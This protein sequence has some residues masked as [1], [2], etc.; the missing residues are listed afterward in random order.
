VQKV[1]SKKNIKPFLFFL[2]VCLLVALYFTGAYENLSFS[3]MK[4]NLDTIQLYYSEQP[5]KFTSI[6]LSIY[7][8]ITALSIPGAIVLTILSGAVY[9]VALGTFLVS[10]ASCIGATIAFF[11]SR[12]FFRDF[13]IARY[14][15]RFEEMD[16][17][18]QDGGKTYLFTMRLIPV[19]PFVVIN[20]FMGLTSVN[21]WTYIWIT[22]V[23]MIPG[24]IVYVFAGR[25]IAEISSPGEILDWSILL[26]FS[27]IGLLPLLV[28]YIQKG[29]KWKHAH[30]SRF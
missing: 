16:R 12:Y 2:L 11:M 20:L 13:F 28:R 3:N 9:G 25:R 10:V 19:S 27:L 30:D 15:E 7:I 24:T 6:F 5:I 29:K 14:R 4:E 21:V 23:G 18:F 1:L 17:K 26:I 8:L 22:F